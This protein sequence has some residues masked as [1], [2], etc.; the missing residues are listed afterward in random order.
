M[1]LETRDRVFVSPP[2]KKV[3]IGSRVPE[4]NREW[5]KR[6]G[7]VTDKAFSNER[8]SFS[9]PISRQIFKNS[10]MIIAVLFICLL[11]AALFEQRRFLT[12]QVYSEQSRGQSL[13]ASNQHLRENL[14]QLSAISLT[15]QSEMN[16]MAGQIQQMTHH[17]RAQLGGLE[18]G[19]AMSGELRH[20]FEKEIGR[21]SSRYDLEV[22]ALRKQVSKK[23]QLISSL[24]ASLQSIEGLVV[25]ADPL[26]NTGG[27]TKGSISAVN[28]DFQFVI[29]NIGEAKGAQ[30][31]QMVELYHRGG[32]IGYGQI[33]KIYPEYSGVKVFSFEVIAQLEKGD[34]ALLK[35]LSGPV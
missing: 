21:M 34:T 7:I 26:P 17:F 22:E 28:Q 13:T 31:G 18:K 32:V 14:A 25:T 9:R 10:I 29:V 5:L 33:E 30:I 23:E 20:I 19:E 16:R 27:M 6:H 11:S 24:E 35:S 8:P 4:E 15:Q 12:E 2:Q 3:R 1:N